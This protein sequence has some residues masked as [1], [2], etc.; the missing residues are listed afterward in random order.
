[1]A[2]ST[3]YNGYKRWDDFHFWFSGKANGWEEQS[4]SFVDDAKGFKVKE[5]RLHFSTAFASVEDFVMYTSSIKASNFNTIWISEPLNGV[6]DLV[7]FFSQP[8]QL[9]SDDQLVFTGSMVS[10]INGYGLEVLGWAARG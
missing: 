1:M 3:E 9:F 4:L 2:F 8:I 7:L 6:R 5:V 10:N